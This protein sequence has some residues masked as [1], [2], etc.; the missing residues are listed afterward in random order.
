MCARVLLD[1]PVG[2]KLPVQDVLSSYFHPMKDS[3]FRAP[4]KILRGVFR[5]TYNKVLPGR[6]FGSGWA[7]FKTT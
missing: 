5:T 2:F 7:F 6:L 3:S 1:L 4:M